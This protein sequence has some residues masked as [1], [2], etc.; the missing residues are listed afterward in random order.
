MRRIVRTGQRINSE[1]VTRRD[2]LG[3]A[4]TLAAGAASATSAPAEETAAPGAN[5]PPNV[6][7]W[8]LAPGA[9]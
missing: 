5:L 6:P 4:A 8:Q 1:P 3:A 9:R 2:V 7:E